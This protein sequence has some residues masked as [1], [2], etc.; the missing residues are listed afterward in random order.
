MNRITT[1]LIAAL[2]ALV[3]VAVGIGIPLV[4]LTILWATSLGMASDWL[5][6]WRASVDRLARRSRGRPHGAT[7]RRRVA[8]TTGLPDAA[9]P[10]TISIALLGF[11]LITALS[12]LRVGRRAVISGDRMIGIGVAA[13]TFA[14]LAALV[15]LSA[16][17]AAVAR[18]ARRAGHRDPRRRLRDRDDHRVGV[19][20]CS[21][22]RRT[23]VMPRRWLRAAS[24]SGRRS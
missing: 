3:V 2:E 22:S 24:A 8:A 6:F 1:A 10:F 19:G 18:P 9:E 23:G 20:D 11:A 16:A 21:G 12:G 4:P 13:V 17:T 7:A 5:P 15:A 14:V